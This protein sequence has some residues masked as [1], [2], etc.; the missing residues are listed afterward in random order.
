[1]GLVPGLGE[2]EKQLIDVSLSPLS[3]KSLSISLGEDKKS[4]S[5]WFKEEHMIKSGP[6]RVSP[7]IFAS[8]G[9]KQV[10]SPWN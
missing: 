10:N 7:R 2:C 6:V 4:D 3:V 8:S 9:E 1:M 5:D